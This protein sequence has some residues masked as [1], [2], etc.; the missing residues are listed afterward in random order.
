MK[1]NKGQ[2]I[3]ILTIV[4]ALTAFFAFTEYKK[5]T[6]RNSTN[7]TIA[8]V[9]RYF[10]G[11]STGPMFEYKY[12]VGDRLYQGG[13][14]VDDEDFSHYQNYFLKLDILHKSGLERNIVERANL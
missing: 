9:F 12:Y 11:T 6:V 5:N 8:M 10:R 14:N 7:Y 1:I 3:G 2:K 13:K 4:T